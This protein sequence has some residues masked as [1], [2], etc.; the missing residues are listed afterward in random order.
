MQGGDN[1]RTQ[2]GQQ[3]QYMAAG[4]T[5][6]NTVFMLQAQD[7]GLVDIYEFRRYAVIVK[8]PLNN[9]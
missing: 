7:I 3:L 6:K 8:E 1:W 5:A 9:D 4:R 2:L